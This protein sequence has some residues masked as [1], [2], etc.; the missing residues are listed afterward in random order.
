MIAAAAAI[1]V[2]AGARRAAAAP[3]PRRVGVVVAVHVNITDKEATRIGGDLG[4][5]LQ[6]KL[7][8]DAVAGD[9]AVRRLPPKGVP[10][11][12]LADAHCIRDIGRRLDVDELLMLVV[13]RVGDEIHIDSTWADVK[14]GQTVSRPAI[15]FDPRTESRTD[16]FAAAAHDLVP[17]AAA[18][19]EPPAR[20]G[21][22]TGKGSAGGGAVAAGIRRGAGGGRHMTEGVWIAG[23]IA[24]AALATSAGFGIATAVRY[25]SAK[26][27]GC[28]NCDAAKSAVSFRGHMADAFLGVAVISAATAAVLYYR[29]DREPSTGG[30][31]VSASPSAIGIAWGGRF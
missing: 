2:I 14:T 19:A 12:C 25:E 18:R 21:T 8:V 6:K 16:V 3:A 10:A 22:G 13:A 11:T 15:S 28:S 27:N 17:E 4:D 9:E 30:V 26:N 20:T 23:G 1:G 29:S 5:A 24:A 31:A 7:V